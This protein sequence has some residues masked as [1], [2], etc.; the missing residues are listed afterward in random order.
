MLGV[1]KPLYMIYFKRIVH[2]WVWTAG[3]KKAF[4]KSRKMLLGSYLLLYYDINNP[5]QLTT[6]ASLLGLG[7]VISHILEDGSESPIIF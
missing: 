1:R 5:L 2:A 4:R 7:A 6:D 3:C